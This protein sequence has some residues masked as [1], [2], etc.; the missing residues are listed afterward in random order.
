MRFSLNRPNR[1]SHRR[2]DAATDGGRAGFVETANS[3]SC[4]VEEP[5]GPY[6]PY[7]SELSR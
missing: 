2:I 5:T 4:P 7:A 1:N 3:E 6:P